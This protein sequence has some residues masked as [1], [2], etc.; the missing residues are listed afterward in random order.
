MS[1]ATS[2][3][4]GLE[5]AGRED[6]AVWLLREAFAIDPSVADGLPFT[7]EPGGGAD[8]GFDL[9]VP[10]RVG[11]VAFRITARAGDFSDGELRPLPVLPVDSFGD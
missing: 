10:A 6:A 1:G 9:Q 5:A 2:V 8:L 3:A 11:T 7:V 4:R